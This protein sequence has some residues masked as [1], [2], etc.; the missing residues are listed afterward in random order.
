M[1]KSE[2]RTMIKEEIQKLKVLMGNAKKGEWNG[3][4]PHSTP[5]W[6]LMDEF[7]TNSPAYKKKEKIEGWNSELVPPYG[8]KEMEIYKKNATI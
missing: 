8:Q 2:I 5:E 4:L 7:F 6:S 1:K 3:T